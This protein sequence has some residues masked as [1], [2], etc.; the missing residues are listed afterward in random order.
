[1]PFQSN[2]FP[3]SSDSVVTHRPYATELYDQSLVDTELCNNYWPR[4]NSSLLPKEYS[5][6][7]ISDDSNSLDFFDKVTGITINGVFMINANSAYHDDIVFPPN[8][9]WSFPLVV[10]ECLGS[11]LDNLVYSY[12]LFS[13]CILPPGSS[14]QYVDFCQNNALCSK[15]EVYYLMTFF[16]NNPQ[17]MTL[18]VIG[19]A[20]DG[21]LIYGPFNAE[22]RLW[23]ACDLDLC[24]GRIING[25]YSYVAT[26]FYPY[27]VGCWGPANPNVDQPSCSAN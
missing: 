7:M 24:N 17:Y 19:L 14:I 23:R 5:F 26:P 20:K 4:A 10:D 12:R 16:K 21:R 1:M 2:L 15:R 6:N 9:N 13:P 27:F 11:N 22:G 3:N 8:G 18:L 25:K